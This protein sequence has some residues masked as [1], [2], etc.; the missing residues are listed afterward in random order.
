MDTIVEPKSFAWSFSRLKAYEDCPRRYHETMVKKAWGEEKSDLLKKG[1]EVHKAMADNLRYGV[2]LPLKYRIYQDWIDKLNNTK[3]HLMVEDECQL[4]INRQFKRTPWFAPDVWLR[5][6]A[7]VIK[8]DLEYPAV[9]HVT[10]W[11]TGKS[12]NG[13]P[14]QLIM[15][16]LVLLCHFEELHAVCSDFVWL[17]GKHPDNTDSMAPRN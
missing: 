15:T 16:S 1:D 6:V 17:Q 4:A 14:I 3:G 7:D 5:C 10:D 11:K 9:A 8:L 2:P 12:I 13:D